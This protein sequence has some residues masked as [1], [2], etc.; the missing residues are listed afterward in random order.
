MK[1]CNCDCKPLSLLPKKKKK[2]SYLGFALLSW[3]TSS[4][5]QRWQKRVCERDG[6]TEDFFS[7]TYCLFCL[8]IIISTICYRAYDKWEKSWW[9]QEETEGEW[10]H[11]GE[12][13]G[14]VGEKDEGQKKGEESVSVAACASTC[15]CLC[16][17]AAACMHVS[18]NTFMHECVCV[19]VAWRVG[20]AGTR[21]AINSRSLT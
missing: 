14:G 18:L 10:E 19:C 12:G 17:S 7:F 8:V 11:K 2:K 16:M 5:C 13:E 6:V 20:A 9:C 15:V 21:R 3:T 4:D 1:L